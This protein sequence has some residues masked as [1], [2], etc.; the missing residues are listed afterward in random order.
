MI[1]IYKIMNDMEKVNRARLIPCL[2][3]KEQEGI[4]LN[5]KASNLEIV[6]EN[7]F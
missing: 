6:K 5:W 4:Q 7:Y 1:D 3:I 2:L